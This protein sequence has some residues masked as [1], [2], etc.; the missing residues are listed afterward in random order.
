MCFLLV[1]LA[2]KRERGEREKKKKNRQ[3]L[4][5]L[6]LCCC[7]APKKPSCVSLHQ[8]P[9]PR[10]ERGRCGAGPA[11]VEVG[12]RCAKTK[13]RGPPPASGKKRPQAPHP[14]AGALPPTA[15]GCPPGSA[16][17]SGLR[18]GARRGGAGSDTSGRQPRC[19]AAA[20][21]RGRRLWPVPLS[22]S[23]CLSACTL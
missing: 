6:L 20:A 2:E 17:G 21:S 16:P 14:R 13:A 18:C 5:F 15:A 4:C 9:G 7:D 19:G 3:D 23:V 22:H 8:R 11:G 10:G 12:G 1:Y